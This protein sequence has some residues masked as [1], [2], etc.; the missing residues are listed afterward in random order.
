MKTCLAEF[1]TSSLSNHPEIIYLRHGE[2]ELGIIPKM[3]AG[4]THFVKKTFDE[5]FYFFRPVSESVLSDTNSFAS[6][7]Q[8]GCFPMVPFSGRIINAMFNYK[9]KTVVLPKH[10]GMPH[11]IH[12]DGWK[13]PWQ[14]IRKNEK[15]I[16]LELTNPQYSWPWDY[17]AELDIELGLQAVFMKLSYTNTSSD[18]VP[19]GIGFHPWFPPDAEL[20]TNMGVEWVVNQN[21]ELIKKIPI[22]D[23]HNFSKFKPISLTNLDTGFS[24]W[25]QKAYVCW[26]NCGYALRLDASPTLSHVILYTTHSSGAWCL[27][28][29][30]HSM[31]SFNLSEKNISGNGTVFLE[32]GGTFAGSIQITITK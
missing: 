29:A 21:Y 18:K 22:P 31:D 32:P 3:G 9:G 28:P 5:V 26:N 14:V 7:E 13:F 20:K 2:L 8:F 4:I 19:V 16:H 15:S 11:A 25:E 6:S 30:S 27:E 10:P 23:E 24:D 17:R 1:N 12:G